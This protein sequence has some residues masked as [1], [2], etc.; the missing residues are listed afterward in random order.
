MEPECLDMRW[1]MSYRFEKDMRQVA[2]RQVPRCLDFAE[3]Y[4]YGIE[5][6]VSYRIADIGLMP[7]ANFDSE[8]A[9]VRTISRLNLVWLSA[10]AHVAGAHEM[11]LDDFRWLLGKS[12]SAHNQIRVIGA[13]CKSGVL[14]YGANGCLQPSEWL[15]RQRSPVVMVEL[16]LTRW[17]E[18]L[19]QASFYLAQADMA[20]VVLDG[21]VAGLVPSEPFRKEGVGL[22]RAWPDK[23]EMIVRPTINTKKSR[24]LCQYNRLRI[25]QDLSRRQP[26]KWA[27]ADTEREPSNATVCPTFIC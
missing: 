22:F 21:D 8:S 15:K 25:I 24:V 23:F 5:V 18:A 27:I 4:A 19:H 7:I 13:L 16:K 14:L 1:N 3:Y 20:C 17:Q 9:E 26:K 11:P 12:V 2:V 6:P 10:L